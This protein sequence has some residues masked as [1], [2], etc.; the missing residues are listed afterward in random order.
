MIRA[1]MDNLVFF[2]YDHGSRAQKVA[3]P[4]IKDFQGV[5]QT[6]GYAVYDSYEH[7]KGVGLMP[8]GSLK[9]N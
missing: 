2:H 5:I 4:F 9:K 3:L 7:K 6:Y 8:V 1:A